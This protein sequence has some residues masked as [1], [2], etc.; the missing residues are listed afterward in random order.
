MA[1][2][3]RLPPDG[4]R[5]RPVLDIA[6][7]RLVAADLLSRRAWTQAELVRRLIR[8][9]APPDVAATVVTDLVRR[10]HVDDAALAQHFAQ[11]RAA[12]GY[13]VARIAADLRARG[14]AADLVT[15]AVTDLDPALH[16]DRA[17]AI[18]RRRLP[19]LA[20]LAPER[21]AVRLRDH[22]LRRGFSASV[23][24]RVVRE[25]LRRDD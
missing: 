25:A 20:R 24:I 22:L 18:A 4:A 9:G 16:L 17:R 21:A 12:R 1:G 5:S 15:A 3:R 14:V 8:R 23:V 19:A 11:T 7:G 10:G 2:R 13:G 6:A